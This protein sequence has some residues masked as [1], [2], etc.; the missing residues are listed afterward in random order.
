MKLNVETGGSSLFPRGGL[1]LLIKK[2][3][4]GNTK[5]IHLFFIP[6]RNFSKDVFLS[7]FFLFSNGYRSFIRGHTGVFGI[8]SLFYWDN[9]ERNVITS[10]KWKFHRSSHWNARIESN[11][12]RYRLACRVENL[13]LVSEPCHLRSV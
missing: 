4:I 11:V 6:F 5:Q 2:L 12:R 10:F 8:E 9:V 1:S 13:L 7:F 3:L